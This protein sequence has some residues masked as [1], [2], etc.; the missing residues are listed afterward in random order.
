MNT[1]I[2]LLDWPYCGMRHCEEHATRVDASGC[3]FCEEHADSGNLRAQSVHVFDPWW[4]F[5]QDERFRDLEY[6]IWPPSVPPPVTA[7][8]QWGLP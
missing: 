7:R 8:P 6:G 3:G 2:T 4:V 1:P 5:S